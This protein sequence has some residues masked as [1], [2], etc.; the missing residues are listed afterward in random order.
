[1][2]LIWCGRLQRGSAAD[3]FVNAA[4]SFSKLYS[5]GNK[6]CLLHAMYNAGADVG[7]GWVKVTC[8]GGRLRQTRVMLGMVFVFCMFNYFGSNVFL[9]VL[10]VQMRFRSSYHWEKHGIGCFSQCHVGADVVQ[11]TD[12]VR[13]YFGGISSSLS[14]APH[15]CFHR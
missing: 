4:H 12:Y 6:A 10:L 2:L 9:D 3:P 13:S 8:V 15:R 7:S 11:R 5:G 1:M 14:Q